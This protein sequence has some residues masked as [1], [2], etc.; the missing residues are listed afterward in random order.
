MTSHS[1]TSKPG[2]VAGEVAHRDGQRLLLVQAGDLDDQLHGAGGVKAT[3]GAVMSR[4]RAEGPALAVL[5]LMMVV[6]LVLRVLH[7]D[8]GLPYV[9]YVDEGSHFTKRAVEIF[10]DANPGYF[11]NPSAYTYLLHLIYRGDRAP[12]RR[13]REGHRAATTRTPRGS[14]RSRA[15]WPRCSASSGV[16]ALYGVGRQLWDR[17]TGLVAAAVLC[18]AFLPVAFSRLAVTDVGTLAPVAIVAARRDP[19]RR[20]RVVA[21]VPRRGR[22]P[23]AWRS[24]SSTPPGSSC[25]RPGW[26]SCC[27]F[28][29]APRPARGG[30]RRSPRSS[31][32]R[33]SRSSSPTRTSSSTSTPRCTSCAARP[34]SPATRTSSARRA[35]A[36]RSTT[37]TA[38]SG[39]SATSPALAALAGAVLLARRDRT[40]L[41]ILLIFPVALFLYLSVQ[42]RF[43]GRWLLPVYPALALLAG[44][45]FMRG[46]ALGPRA[47]PALALGGPRR[48]LG[49]AAVAAARRRRPLDGRARQRGHAR[50]RAP[51]ARR[52]L[53]PRPAGGDRAGGAGPLPVPDH[54]RPPAQHARRRSSSTSSSATRARSTSSTAARS[55]PGCSTATAPRLL[56]GDDLRPDPRPRGGVRRPRARSPTTAGSSGSPTSSSR[57][58]RTARTSPRSRSASTSA[59]AT[60][61]RPTSGPGRRRGSTGCATARSATGR[62]ADVSAAG[63]A[64]AL[65]GAILLRRPRAARSGTSATACRSPTTPT[66]PSTSSPR[67]SGCSATGW[68]RATTR[69]RRALTYLLYAVFNVRSAASRSRGVDA[70]SAFL[71]ARVVVAL[72]GTL[73]VGLTYWAGA[74]FADRRAGL[75]A[76]AVMAV[77][78]LPV[79]YS[80][81]ALNDVVTLAPVTLA[82]VACL[83][84]YRAGRIEDWLLAGGGDRRRR[85]RRSTRRGRCSL[86]VLLAA[87]AARAARPRGAAPRG[88]SASSLAGV[89]CLVVFAILNPFV[90]LN[91][92]EARGQITGQSAQ[93][94]TA[95]LGQDDTLRLALLPGHADL[96]ARLGAAAR[97]GG[98]R[99]GDPAARL[100]DRA[101]ARRLPGPLLPLHGRAGPL[102]RPL[103]AA[104]LPGALRAGRDRGGRGRRA[105]ARAPRLGPRRASP[106]CCASRGCWRASTSTSCSGREDTRAQA[107]RW[108]RENVPPGA[109]L[110]VEPF[111]PA[112]WQDALQRPLWPVPR[113]FQAYEKRLRVRQI[114]RY[115]RRG[116]CWVIVGSTQKERG[117]KAGLRS[118]QQLLPGARRGERGDGAASRR[119]REG[120]DGVGFSY[121]SSFNY[122]P[123]DFERPG[124]GRRDPSA[125]RLHA[126]G[127]VIRRRCP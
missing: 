117:L 52:A 101:A 20:G 125:A 26:R 38:C 12:V 73:V 17:R 114:E 14:S 66:R 71:T 126:G 82:L 3:I 105:A 53:A 75:V 115:R 36:G 19:D 15:G 16:A 41:A 116:F 74:R 107:L 46:L 95:K 84:A 64:W 35:T 79:F 29:A 103:A 60:T 99:G 88:A 49:R 87:G 122:R 119:S 93:A 27:A 7:N 42:S 25:S 86:T 94:D 59:T 51:V 57:S 81:H 50:D 63:R 45:A 37:S 96:G 43:F 32:G 33:C 69:T 1:T 18:F 67:R 8:H 89:A 56:H 108:V 111:V 106:R 48:R 31:A 40:R 44:Y 9:Y 77:A 98:R 118:S 92:S 80:K 70:A 120:S 23:P 104:D 55:R 58:A 65:L 24:A 76:A 85:P 68:T 61:R 127:R 28:A 102:L 112:S 4:L 34:S 47:G 97:R 91:P 11:Q 72:I 62:G 123:R 5:G 110:V 39:A 30:A 2:D 109:P 10:R 22:S 54:R 124:P 121:D 78:F 100:A 6:G 21:L 90:I 83:F 13:R 113:P